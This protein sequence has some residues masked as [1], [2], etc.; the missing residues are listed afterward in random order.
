MSTHSRMINCFDI[1]RNLLLSIPFK[2]SYNIVNLPPLL[3][4]RYGRS[5]LGILG[6]SIFL[7]ISKILPP[8]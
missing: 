8:T 4:T 7:E 1:S 5:E 3:S 2:L 6:W